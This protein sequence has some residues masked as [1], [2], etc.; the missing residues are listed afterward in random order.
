MSEPVIFY[1]SIYVFSLL[2][3]G[4]LMTIREFSFLNRREQRHASK[5][6][7]VTRL[8]THSTVG[9]GLGYSGA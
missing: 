8:R 9:Y 1:T 2:M 3:I 5:E 7:R 4:L 6:K